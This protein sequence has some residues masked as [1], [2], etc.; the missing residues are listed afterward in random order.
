MTESRIRRLANDLRETVKLLGV[1]YVPTR[2]ECELYIRDSIEGSE[3]SK[4]HETRCYIKHGC[5]YV[6][7]VEAWYELTV[8]MGGIEAVREM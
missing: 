3:F 2:K 8:K 5:T 4:S 6:R 1:D 7:L